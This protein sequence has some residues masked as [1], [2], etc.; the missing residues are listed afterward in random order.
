MAGHSKWANI[1]HKKAAQ[2][3]KRGKV[4]S[5]ISKKLS[6]AARRGGGDPDMN[7]EL[8]L[9][10][11]KARA[12]NMPA[13]NIQRVILKATGQLPGVSMESF[14]YEGYGAGGVAIFLEGSTDNKNRTVSNIR[15]AFSR[16]GGNLGAN[17]CVS[18]MFHAKGLISIAEDQ[19]SDLDSLMEVAMENGA[20]DFEDE[21]GVITL[22][23]AVEDYMTLRDALVAH[24][25]EDFLSDE[26]TR[27]AETTTEPSLEEVRQNLR[28]IELLEDDDDIESVYHNMDMSDE[29]ASALEE[30]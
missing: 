30:E 11:Q 12:A 7:A 28:L 10:I 2:D 9:Y 6:S 23:T 27:I 16:N 14:T 13:D 3:A 1:K 29:V 20:E 21:G 25:I 15:Y 22:T 24:G 26:I 5:V 18:W 19:V 17:G 8:R 4:F